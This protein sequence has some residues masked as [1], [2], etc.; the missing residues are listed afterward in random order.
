MDAPALKAD[1]R[2]LLD[3]DAM[4]RMEDDAADKIHAALQKWGRALFRDVTADSVAALVTRLDNADFSK[5]LRDALIAILQDVAEAGAD[6]GR[7]QIMAAVYGVKAEARIDPAAVDWTAANNDAAQWATEYG[8]QLVRG[9]TDTTRARIANEIRYFVDNS[10]TINQLRDRL[11]EGSLFSRARAGMIAATE[12]TR[13]YAEGN[14]RAWQ[15]SGVVEAREWV[16]AN[17]EIVCKVCGPLHGSIAKMGDW[18]GGRYR[19]PPAHVGCRCVVLPVVIGD[20]ERFAN[21]F[22]L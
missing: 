8:Y 2:L 5:P 14:T 22:G 21:P 12:V 17:D 15:K 10:L 18:F 20:D 4:R 3:V 6:A 13:A 16:T 7:G 1:S 11:M 9:I 19:N